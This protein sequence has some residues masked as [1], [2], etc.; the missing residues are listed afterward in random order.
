MFDYAYAAALEVNPC[1][2]NYHITD[3]SAPPPP[4]RQTMRNADFID[5]PIHLLP[6][7]HSQSGMSPLSKQAYSPLLTSPGRLLSPRRPGLLQPHRR[8]RRNQCP[9]HQLGTVH[10]QQRLRA[11]RS[12]LQLK[13]HLPCACADRRPPSRH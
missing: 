2:N 8:P 11:G 3:V 4:L 1:F 9:P 7:R 5:L 13:R 12:K 10:A 6:A